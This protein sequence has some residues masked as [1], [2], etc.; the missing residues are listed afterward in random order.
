MTGTRVQFYNGILLL[1]S[2]FTCR[3]VYGT[4]Q[5]FCVFRD[6]WSAIGVSPNFEQLGPTAMLFAKDNA[7]IPLW[8]AASYL[9]SNVT[10]NT[11]NFYWFF[12]MVRAVRKRFEPA[13]D[14]TGKEPITEVEV[15]LSSVTSGVPAS[16]HPRRRKA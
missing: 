16:A 8:L 9:A 4:Y 2:F 14:E 13:R 6:I 5:S 1:F 3:L 11:L 7:A 12:M 15:D 10:L